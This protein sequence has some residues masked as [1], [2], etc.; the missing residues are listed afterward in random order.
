MLYKK[1][2]ATEL[3]KRLFEN[4]TSEY[5]A[6]PFWAWNCKVTPE[7]ITKQIGILKEMGFGGYHI[8]SRTGMDVPYLSDE[9]MS[10]IR[11]CVEEAKRTDTLAWLYDEDRWPSGAAGGLVTKEPEYRQRFMRFTKNEITS[12]TAP[13]DEAVKTGKP[14][15]I[16]AY[17][18]VLDDDGYISEYK[19]INPSDDAEGDKWFAYC[20]TFAPSGWFN[21]QTYVDTLSKK[22]IDRFI[23][24]THE[25]YKETVGE[26][27]DKIVP[28]IFT[29]EPSPSHKTMLPTSKSC[30][31]VN[32]PWT[33]EFDKIFSER[34]GMEI[35]KALP[36]LIF[37]KKYGISKARYLYHELVCELFTEAFADNCGDWC[38]KNGLNMTGHMLQEDSL[39]AQ[40]GHNGEVMRAYRRFH[41]PG[42]DML[43][44]AHNYTTAK[45][46]QSAVHQYGREGM[47]CE[48][49][50]VTDW[51]F[52]FRGHKHH[53]DWQAAL[54]VTVR[55][56]HLAWMSMHGDAKR[57]YP[58]SIFYQS[59]WYKE[60]P[61]IEN[62]F[63]RLNTALTRGKPVVDIA[64][65]H[66]VESYW[67]HWGPSDKTAIVRSELEKCFNDTANWLL[68]SGLDF[69]YIDE[70]LLPELYSGSENGEMTVG[71]MKYKA[72][73]VPVL[74]TM[75][76]TTL[77]AL[78]DF[79]KA[80]GTV[81]FMGDMPK[82][83]DAEPSDAAGTLY[84]DSEKIPYSRDELIR[85]LKPFRHIEMRLDNGELASNFLYNYREDGD[86]RWL[87]VCHGSIPSS[88][89]NWAK[90]HERE[91]LTLTIDGE[92]TP[93]VYNTLNGKTENIDYTVNNGKT[94]LRRVFYSHDSLLLRL[95]PYDGGV[96]CTAPSV[97]DYHDNI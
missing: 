34:F 66:P 2:S 45:Q 70:G 32:L 77:K 69:D 57:D 96:R 58:A 13:K 93:V 21:N 71:K 83:I 22:A 56:P 61:Y 3:D 87:F 43:C 28:A 82:Y 38:E 88:R 37:E 97:R 46:C 53:G 68:F 92:Y 12:R 80:G 86:S 35:D 42:I 36:E 8:H 65:I 25:R 49:Y 6:A 78:E 81:I 44:G 90:N 73:V 14:Y 51:D 40:T 26:E 64:V 4:P 1:N 62:H 20:E 55:V 95:L 48:L 94:T 16:G 5:R 52:D 72:I 19:S 67:L 41:I 47:M 75:R 63:A 54:G 59:P 74:E 91:P 24:I 50:G 60:Y 15:L 17:D 84:N 79:R 10:L 85:A 18:V 89:E 11:H 31:D 9:F 29:D 23:E 33:P 7:I 39:G 27:F 76:G 30:N